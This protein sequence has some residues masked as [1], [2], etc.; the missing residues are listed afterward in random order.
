MNISKHVYI[1]L[2]SVF[3]LVLVTACGDK[4]GGITEPV[5]QPPTISSISPEEGAIGTE[6]TILGSNFS[7]NTTV[8][9]DGEDATDID[10]ESSSTIY[11]RVPTG[12][13]GETPVNVTVRNSDGQEAT[14]EGAFTAIIPELL[15]VNSATLPSGNI[16]STVIFEGRAFGDNQGDSKVFFSD[17]A[18]GEIEAVI[19]SPDDW[20]D[21]FIVTTVPDGV[22]DGSVYVETE[23]GTSEPIQFRITDAAT[24]SPSEIIWSETLSLPEAISGHKAVYTPLIGDNG[25]TQRYVFVS[26][27]RDENSDALDQV[28]YGRITSTGD[29]ESWNQNTPLPQNLS[30]HSSV[31]ATPFNSRI[32]SAG[33]VYVLG[34]VNSEREPISDVYIGRLQND[35]T[36]TSWRDGTPLPQPLHSVGAVIF[37][38]NIYISGGSTTDNEPVATV[39]RAEIDDDGN[40]GE[41]QDL[42]SL[43]SVTTYHGFVSFGGYLY[44]VGG[45][46]GAVL[47]DDGNSQNNDTKLGDVRYARVDLRSGN[48]TDAGWV[49]NESEL[50]KN[51]SKHSTVVVGGAMF[52]SSGLYSAAG[53]GSSENVY[54]VINSDGTVGSFNGA[55]GSNTLGSVGD[56]INRFNQ[57]GIS[58]I[59]ENGE[60]HVMIIGGDSVNNPGTKTR[61]VLFY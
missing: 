8:L 2:I 21:T 48:L 20:T 40:I 4:N 10:F 32:S 17:G 59:D 23:I 58:Y 12:I 22:D 50:Q 49:L 37:R 39:Y 41:W 33:E 26:G 53:Q 25:E 5:I 44:S 45:E 42:P 15:F 61:D 52:V 1:V 36:I 35:A 24:F 6:L 18:G 55:T 30:F 27:G 19:S 9:V 13:A 3:T 47:P 51:R 34:G 38:S 28:L 60:N 54:G 31:S 11:A 29:I 46:S 16:G 14:L 7:T 43:P 56:Q 57:S